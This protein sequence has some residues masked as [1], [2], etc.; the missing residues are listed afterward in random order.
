MIHRFLTVLALWLGLFSLAF[1][2]QT[3]PSGCEDLSGIGETPLVDFESQIQPLLNNCAGCHGA[4]GNA[5]LDLR[6][7]ESYDN[8]VGVFANTNPSRMRAEPFNAED[9]VLLLAINCAQPGGPGF[10]MPNISDPNDV[11][12]I[13]DWINQGAWPEPREVAI[14]EDVEL[15]EV[16]APGTFPAALGLVNAG[17][18]SGR[19]FVIGQGGRVSAVSGSGVISTFIDLSDRTF[20]SGERGLLGLAFHPDFASNGRFFVNY[21]AG[22]NHPSGAALGDTVIAEFTIDGSGNGNPDSE[23]VIM[24]VHQDFTNHNGGNIKFGPDGYL[25]IGMGDGGDSGDPCNR[26]QTLDPN[27]LLTAPTNCPNNPPTS[28]ALLGKMLRI[29]IDRT[30]A[31]GSNNLCAA[32]ADG[33]AEYA[34][35]DDNPFLPDLIFGDRFESPSSERLDGPCGEIWSY[36]LRNPWRWSFDRATGDMWIADVGQGHWEEINLEPAGHGGG[37]DYGWKLCEASYTFPP[38]GAAQQC[39]HEHSFPVLEYSISG[40][41]ECAVTGGYR[42][43]GPVAS[44]QGLY[45][46]GDFCSGRVWFG[47]QVGANDFEALVFDHGHDFADLRSFG[48]DEAG[49]VYLVNDGG[50]WR[51]DGGSDATVHSLNPR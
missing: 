13:R 43:R 18:G 7:G 4:A 39:A 27:N 9:S 32:N 46:Y 6:A 47:F 25:Y 26:A 38:Q 48:E 1:S 36:G 24:T 19:L 5:G 30:T 37:A 20:G 50:I 15:V 51:F 35:P 28:A 29:D 45:I 49:N 33:S 42:Y 22:S 2:G 44:L 3:A 23:R 17:D 16:H 21:T 40:Q 34:I 8:L 31:A 11:A 41:D 14:P 10:P 12:L